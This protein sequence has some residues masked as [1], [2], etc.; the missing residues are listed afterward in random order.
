VHE[1]PHSAV[2]TGREVV[3]NLLPT[4]LDR[5]SRCVVDVSAARGRADVDG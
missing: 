5:T 1:N 3:R 2:I 4:A